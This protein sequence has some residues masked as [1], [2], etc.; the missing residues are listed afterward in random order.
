M[1]FSFD[2]NVVRVNLND[3]GQHGSLAAE[4]YGPIALYIGG[5]GKVE[6]KDIAIADLSLKTR[7]PDYTS[8]TSASRR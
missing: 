7:E 4:G 1:E 6:Y 5:T 8:S 3:G 2:A